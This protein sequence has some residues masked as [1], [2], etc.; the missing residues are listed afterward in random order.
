MTR[1]RQALGNTKILRLR[2]SH[3]KYRSRCCVKAAIMDY[4]YPSSVEIMM[5][6][7]LH[8][9]GGW[10]SAPFF[11]AWTFG[12]DE[13]SDVQPKCVCYTCSHAIMMSKCRRFKPLNFLGLE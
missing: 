11:A 5:D 4:V 2:A 9:T 3:V 6:V 7:A 1:C 10:V 8:G 12:V 13:T